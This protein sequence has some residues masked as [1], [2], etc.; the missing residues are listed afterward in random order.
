MAY[1]LVI[2]CILSTNNQAFGQK[3]WT[4]RECIS[5]AAEN[6]I[7][8]KQQELNVESQKNTLNTA[9][10]SR[11]PGIS[12]SANQNFNFG[13]GLTIDNTYANRNTQSTSFGIGADLPLYTGGQINH[14]IKARKLDHQTAIAD[15]Q[16][17]K[18][19]ISIQVVS[20]YLEVLFQ[21]DLLKVSADQIELSKMQEKRIQTLFD[22]GKCAEIDLAEIKASVANDQLSYVQ[23]EN[24]YHLALLTLTQLLEY[25]TPDSFDVATPSTDDYNINI[26]LPEPNKVYAEATM[27]KPQIEAQ[28]LRL[29]SAE[30]NIRIARSGYYPNISLSAGIS[31]NYYKTSGFY[32]A[33]FSDQMRDNL[34]KSFSLSLSI[35]IFN[36][37]NTRNSIRSAKLQHNTQLLQLEETRK[38]LYKEIQQAY[39]NAI[40]AQKQ[41]KSSMTAEDASKSS[42]NLMTAKFVNGKATATEYQEAKTALLKATSNRIQAQY[43]FIFRQKILDF[44]R[45]V[46]L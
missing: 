41:C 10:S 1:L 12:A 20:A 40:A 23:Q 34:N 8:I 27:V 3:K 11:L 33:P 32:A 19:N 29:K 37:F 35:P 4:L 7:N 25:P 14:T 31:T 43:T 24:N 13:R 28:T 9:K 38:T 21:K 26:I 5:Y 16:Y 36:R 2:L 17:A 30:E 18:D 6:N 22:N 39:Y 45:G 44:Y 42:F 46:E 15:L